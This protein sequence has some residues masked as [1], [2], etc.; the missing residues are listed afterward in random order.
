MLP[1]KLKVMINNLNLKTNKLFLVIMYIYIT[2]FTGII[3]WLL[4]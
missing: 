3:T 2:V 1:F 4:L